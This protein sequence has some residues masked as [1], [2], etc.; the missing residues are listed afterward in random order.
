MPESLTERYARS[1]AYLE[2]AEAVIPLG[3]QTFSKSRTQYP[4]G[5]APLFATRSSASHTWDINGN[6][7]VDLGNR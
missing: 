1:T 7:Y 3:S 5:A 4:V 6:E 2:R